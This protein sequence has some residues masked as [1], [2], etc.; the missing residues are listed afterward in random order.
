MKVEEKDAAQKG[1]PHSYIEGLW[2]DMYLEGRWSLPINSNP[3]LALKPPPKDSAVPPGSDPQIVGA[4]RFVEGSVQ[5]GGFCL[6]LACESVCGAAPATSVAHR[7]IQSSEALD[8]NVFFFVAVGTG[9]V[10]WGAFRWFGDYGSSSTHSL[11]CDAS[12]PARQ[13]CDT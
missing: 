3:Y 4:A 11:S 10:S 9:C 7:Q 13:S 6:M 8:Y 5:G 2:D 1:Y 12:G